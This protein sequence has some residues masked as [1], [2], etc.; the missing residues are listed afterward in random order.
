MGNE[1][2]ATAPTVSE[3]ATFHAQTDEH[4]R[5]TVT[6]TGHWTLRGIGQRAHALAEALRPYTGKSPEIA[7]D[8]QE[9]Q[10]LDNVGALI[11]WRLH[12]FTYPTAVKVRM[13]HQALF[14]RWSERQTPPKTESLR[15]RRLGD[16]FLAM[17]E[18]LLSHIIDFATLLGQIVL[19]V[20]FLARRPAQIPWKD[21]SATVYE[22]G[23]RALGITALVGALVGVVMSYLSALELQAFGAQPFIVN[24]LGLSILRELGPLLA[25]I[26]VAGRSGS[27]MAAELGVMRLTEELDALSAMG[28]SRTL[29]LVLPK[30]VAL[31]VSLPLLVIWTDAIALIGGMVTAHIALGISIPSFLHALPSAVPVIN[32]I[33]GIIK[34]GVFG[35]VI[36]LVACHFGLR[37]QPNTQSLGAETTN[38]VVTAIT[39]VIFV[40]AVFA[41]AFRGTGL[42]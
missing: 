1:R 31:G 11:L 22:V 2:Q 16:V 38:A 35:V 12:G 39:A 21:I 8:C 3:P 32:L 20:V 36:A 10:A 26:L 33:L 19:D 30:L 18:K 34:G 7:W 23:V 40:D 24:V 13:E 17:E 4:G 15:R 25:A 28:I 5:T 41:I 42:P 29:R 37:I 9:V 14:H 27:A 6:L